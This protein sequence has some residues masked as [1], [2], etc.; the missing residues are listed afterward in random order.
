M[1]KNVRWW[2]QLPGWR[3]ATALPLY[4][5]RIRKWHNFF[6]SNAPFP[7]TQKGIFPY[8]PTDGRWGA[9]GR[10]ATPY[11]RK[12]SHT[13]LF[14]AQ[15]IET[16]VIYPSKSSISMHFRNYWISV[17]KLCLNSRTPE[18]DLRW[19]HWWIASHLFRLV[20]MREGKRK[21]VRS[22]GG[23][24]GPTAFIQFFYLRNGSWFSWNHSFINH[25]PTPDKMTM[26]GNMQFILLLLISMLL[27][28]R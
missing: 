10:I 22:H 25:E 12:Y 1:L 16:C 19:A 18:M 11:M 27:Q 7:K 8:F 13:Y 17:Q 24:V 6:F 15:P 28:L 21:A 2:S 20:K 23:A 4:P 14:L 5:P 9:I 3:H 26:L